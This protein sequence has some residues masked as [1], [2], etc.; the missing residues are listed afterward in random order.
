[1]A[2]IPIFLWDGH[3]ARPDWAGK[4]P[5]PQGIEECTHRA[6][7]GAIMPKSSGVPC[8]RIFKDEGSSAAGAGVV[9][10][11]NS[12]IGAGAAM[13]WGKKIRALT[14]TRDNT[15]INTTIR[16]AIY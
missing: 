15:N 4:M 10:E 13:S 14:A 5:T 16:G 2:E 8:I 3:L 6:Y 1:M 11:L 12:S 7:Q 9:G